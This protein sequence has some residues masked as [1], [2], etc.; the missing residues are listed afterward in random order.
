MFAVS[1]PVIASKTLD[2]IN[3]ALQQDR[4]NLFRKHLRETIPHAEDA[5][6]EDN[7]PF[8]THLGAS[9]IGRDCTRELFY[10]FRWTTHPDYI[11]EYHDGQCLG[12]PAQLC[13]A[14]V[15][16]RGRMQR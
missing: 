12:P 11:P 7:D 1:G 9:L 2:A 8:R 13:P 4:G 15:E 16:R 5:Y 14:C 6:R 3:S 10:T